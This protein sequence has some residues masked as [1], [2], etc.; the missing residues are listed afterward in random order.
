MAC[1]GPWQA[2]KTPGHGIDTCDVASAD[3][4]RF[5]RQGR[6]RVDG[7]QYVVMENAS[8][9]QVSCSAQV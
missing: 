9:M 8:A 1:R 7:R 6:R 2:K 4:E 3:S 5:N